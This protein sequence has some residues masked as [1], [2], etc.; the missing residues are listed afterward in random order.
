[1]KRLRLLLFLVLPA[2]AL[3]VTYRVDPA[4]GPDGLSAAVAAAFAAWQGLDETLEVAENS[5]T[6]TENVPVFRYGDAA[7][8]GDDTLSL[9]VQRQNGGLEILV[10]PTTG[11]LAANALL[12][13][14]GLLLDLA[15]ANSGV[16]NPA[17]PEEPLS[18]GDA[19][20]TA[21]GTLL[22]SVKED[23]NRDGAVDF[24]DLVALAQSYGQPGI[25]EPADINDDGLVDRT[26]L[27]LLQAAYVFAPPS[28]TGPP[29]TGAMGDETSD[30]ASSDAED[31][32]A[33]DLEPGDESAGDALPAGPQDDAQP[34]DQDTQT[35]PG[36]GIDGD[37]ID[38]DG[39]DGDNPGD[40]AS[41]G[42]EP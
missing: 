23:V 18:L 15:V 41:D 26:D 38:G 17:L 10:T 32:E 39:I 16:M 35:L 2:T 27:E 1:M 42:D 3:A 25:N 11:P 14:A 24:Y 4:G 40:D 30:E 19:E 29:Q 13:E 6:G 37:G 12:H 5:D 8:L 20:Q 21:L 34:T 9:T 33:E 31:L 22:T 36:D 28:S 7:L